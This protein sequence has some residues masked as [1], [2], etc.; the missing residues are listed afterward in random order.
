MLEIPYWKFL[1]QGKPLLADISLSVQ[2]SLL[3]RKLSI[4]T[5][6]LVLRPPI[7]SSEQIALG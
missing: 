6:F 1:G 7:G 4:P 3:E 2:L 5:S